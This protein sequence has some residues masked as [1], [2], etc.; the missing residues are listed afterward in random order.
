MATSLKSA[1]EC[2]RDSRVRAPVFATRPDIVAYGLDVTKR[3]VT[4]AER[5]QPVSIPDDGVARADELAASAGI[6]RE[7]LR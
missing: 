5:G 3:D 7:T 1:G 2:A 6:M 4:F